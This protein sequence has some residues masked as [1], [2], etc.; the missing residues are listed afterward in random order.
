VA[1]L[2]CNLVWKILLMKGEKELLDVSASKT[3]KEVA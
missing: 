1:A 2:V 3:S